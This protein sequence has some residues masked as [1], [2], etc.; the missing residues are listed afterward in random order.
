[1]SQRFKRAEQLVAR[2][3]GTRRTPLSGSNSGHTASDTLHPELF[4]EVKLRR[5]PPHWDQ[6]HELDKRAGRRGLAPLIVVDQVG[7]D[8]RLFLTRFDSFLEMELHEHPD[9]GGLFDTFLVEHVATKRSALFSLWSKVEGQARDEGKVPLVVYKVS[10]RP[11][12]LVVWRPVEAC[13]PLATMPRGHGPRSAEGPCPQE[14][15]KFDADSSELDPE[16]GAVDRRVQPYEGR[17]D[18][19]WP[20]RRRRGDRGGDE[21]EGPRPRGRDVHRTAGQADVLHA[22]VAPGAGGR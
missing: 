20:S 22:R 16:G 17:P 19:G 5:R 15:K 11:G 7:T 9:V 12:E 14:V 13:A 6:L 18:T 8:L 2:K 1:M 3:L 4:V 21:S 10:G